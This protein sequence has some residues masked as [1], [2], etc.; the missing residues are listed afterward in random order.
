MKN[1]IVITLLFFA[2]IGCSVNNKITSINY[3]QLSLFE[4]NQK[5]DNLIRMYNNKVSIL[6][7]K[8]LIAENKTPALGKFGWDEVREYWANIP[9]LG[10]L[11][12]EFERAEGE[13]MAFKMKNDNNFKVAYKL[14]EK[15]EISQKFFYKRTKYTTEKVRAIN[16]K[17]YERLRKNYTNTLGIS[18]RETFKYII[19]DYNEKEKT[20]SI[21]WI[22]V[23]NIEKINNNILIKKYLLELDNIQNEIIKRQ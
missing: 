20:I 22:P 11:R 13:Y 17:E 9:K 23:K 2:L 1:S 16:P 21:D 8:Y 3:S 5:Y 7:S 4:L 15:K 19:S 6:Y 10:D 12:E 18:N 14:Y